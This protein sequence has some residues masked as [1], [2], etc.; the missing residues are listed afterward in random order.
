MANTFVCLGLYAQAA[1]SWD[2]T[3]G[4]VGK[5]V[6]SVS[7][8]QDKAYGIAIQADGKI[9]V[10]GYG[11]NTTTGKDF[12]LVRYNTD[13]SLDAN[14]GVSGIVTT[15]LQTN[16]EDVAYAMALQADGK[17]VLGG[18]SDNGVGRDAA[19][20]RYNADGTIDTGFGASGIVLTD[21]D[22]LRTD[23]IKALKIHTATGNIVVGGSAAASASIGKPILARYTSSGALDTAFNTTGIKSL[24]VAVNDNNR[25]F[26]VED[27][28]VEANGVISCVGW[29]KQV[30]TSIVSQYWAGRVLS[31]GAMDLSFSADGVV[32]YGE[33]GSSYAMGLVLNGNRDIVL[34]GY[35][36]YFGDNSYRTL[37]INQ[38]GDINTGSTVYT[39]GLSG[40]ARL[41]KI[42]IDNNGKYIVVGTT[43]T[44]TNS[45][46]N[47]GR[48]HSDLSTDTTFAS[49]G[50][51]STYFGNAINEGYNVA[52]Q[53][54]N[55]IVAV[56]ATGN[57]F[58][59][60]RFLG[61]PQ[62]Q[63]NGFQLV[64]PTNLSQGMNFAN[65]NFNWS[66]AFG[67]TSY[68]IDIDVSAT[69]AT[70][71]TFTTTASGYAATNLQPN[72]MY[73]WRVRASDGNNWGAYSNVW[74]FTTDNLDNFNL[75]SPA[76]GA[77]NSNFAALALDW[78]T[79]ISASTYELQIDTSADF[80]TSPATYT[81]ANSAYTLTLLPSTTY[82]WKVRAG[83]AGTWGQWTAAWS[84]TTAAPVPI[85][86]QENQL[87]AFRIYPNPV[88]DLLTIEVDAHLLNKPYTLLDNT[89]KE[90]QSGL[91]HSEQTNLQL[92]ELAAGT[93]YVRIGNAQQKAQAILKK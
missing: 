69:F 14:F 20:V 1:G 50:F 71:Q 37:Q 22:T 74:R 87:S 84:F 24:A 7:A 19:L 52:V 31:N 40:V 66:D 79:N 4:S 57:D 89:G 12:A 68:E 30:S 85:A 82:Y 11:T 83:H 41:H 86:L 27:L 25:I 16:S 81:S 80:S 93:Y 51:P 9:L 10:A 65:L 45:F 28:V 42:T 59:V 92:G 5:V 53:S 75:L 8:G 76:N 13:G 91:L 44:T 67:A 78:A 18:Y 63:L 47:I 60:V 54:D 6:T 21:F 33:A 70:A 64:A 3:F 90:I 23:E 38:N 56:G 29:R 36:Q 48:L 72:T 55:K 26:A 61:Y 2:V 17:I 39:S 73:F 15:D 34:C 43:G 46:M 88:A 62:P 77:T 35:R 58:A 32:Q 49:Y